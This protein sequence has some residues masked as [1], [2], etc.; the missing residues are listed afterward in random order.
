M[1]LQW[2]TALSANDGAAFYLPWSEN[3]AFVP[4]TLDRHTSLLGPHY[5]ATLS[6]LPCFIPYMPDNTSMEYEF[7]TLSVL[8]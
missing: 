4:V 6:Q 2:V 7:Y 1:L 3:A 5:F 8:E